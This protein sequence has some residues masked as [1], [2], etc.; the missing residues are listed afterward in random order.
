[1]ASETQSQGRRPTFC[2]IGI[3]SSRPRDHRDGLLGVK[4]RVFRHREMKS[5][6][7]W[8]LLPK[9]ATFHA[10]TRRIAPSR[11]S[12]DASPPHAPHPARPARC[13]R[14]FAHRLLTRRARSACHARCAAPDAPPHPRP[15]PRA[16]RP[17]RAP[18]SSRIAPRA[19]S[20]H[21]HSRPSPRQIAS[22]IAT[23]CH[24]PAVR[25]ARAAVATPHA[26]G[27]PDPAHRLQQGGGPEHLGGRT[28]PANRDAVP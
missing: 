15:P 18:A 4:S 24:L 21:P 11:A 14:I 19:A 20:R 17:I 3:A 16:P 25:E 26:H 5:R 27:R 9:T 22:P 10:S 13:P 23:A 1:M 7:F 28:A 6:D 8:H 12:P 2:L